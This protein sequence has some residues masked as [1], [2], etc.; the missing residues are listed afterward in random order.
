M[1]ATKIIITYLLTNQPK[2]QLKRHESQIKVNQQTQSAN[3]KPL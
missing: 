3:Q 2:R 1:K